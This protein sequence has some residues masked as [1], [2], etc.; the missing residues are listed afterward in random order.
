MK[1]FGRL[2]LVA[3]EQG[4]YELKRLA[5]LGDK[6]IKDKTNVVTTGK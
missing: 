4:E 2:V 3:K 5:P 6:N 1:Y